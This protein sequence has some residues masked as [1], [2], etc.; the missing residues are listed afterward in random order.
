[1]LNLSYSLRVLEL[2][3]SNVFHLVLKF[4]TRY[5]FHLNLTLTPRKVPNAAMQAVDYLLLT[6]ASIPKKSLGRY[7]NLSDKLNTPK[8]NNL[9]LSTPIL[10]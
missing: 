9:A 7:I 10:L 4:H 3:Y 5:L 1:M 8:L 2:K 6:V